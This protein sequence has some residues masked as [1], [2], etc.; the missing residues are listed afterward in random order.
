MRCSTSLKNTLA[1]GPAISLLGNMMDQEENLTNDGT[2]K[3]KLGALHTRCHCRW[4]FY[5]LRSS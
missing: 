3:V 5:Y 4:R 2:V 1:C